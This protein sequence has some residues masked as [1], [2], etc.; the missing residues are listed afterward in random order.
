MALE[1]KTAIVTGGA[2]GIG[3]AIARRYLQDGARIVIADLDEEAGEAAADALDALGEVRFVAADVSEALDVHNLVAE[4]LDAFEAIDILVNNAGIA[5]SAP[6]LDIEEGDFDRVLRSNLKSGFLCSQA[7]ARLM[8]QRVAQEGP[9]GTI[10]NMAALDAHLAS[11]DQLSYAVSKAGVSQL[12]AVMAV[13]LA[14][15]GIRV[16]AIAPGTIQT[17]M[18]TWLGEDQELRRQ[19]LARTPLG[20]IGEPSE[21]AGIAAFLASEDASYMT[22]QTLYADGGR[23]RLDRAMPLPE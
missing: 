13:A 17:D 8:V 22:G 23:L 6:F 20:R 10:I 18:L 7:V 1:G 9:A 14:P 2:R 12:T 3:Y 19:V 16:N 4:T 21:I 11:A 5:H 15:H